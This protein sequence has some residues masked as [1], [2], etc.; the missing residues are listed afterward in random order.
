MCAAAQENI[1]VLVEWAMLE[2]EGIADRNIRT[3]VHSP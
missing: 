2:E 3:L 1:S